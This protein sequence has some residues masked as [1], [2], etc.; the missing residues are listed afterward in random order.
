[1]CPLQ[2]LV[3]ARA[4]AVIGASAEYAVGAPEALASVWGSVDERERRGCA[5]RVRGA[6]GPSAFGRAWIVR[7]RPAPSANRQPRQLG[8]DH[9]GMVLL[10]PFGWHSVHGRQA[11]LAYPC[12]ECVLWFFAAF[13]ATSRRRPGQS[14]SRAGLSLSNRGKPLRRR[15][16]GCGE[17]PGRLERVRGI[18]PT[19]NTPRCTR[20]GS[21]LRHWRTSHPNMSMMSVDPPR[22]GDIA[23]G[24]LE[25]RLSQV[26]VAVEPQLY[27]LST[28][29]A[30]LDVECG[31]HHAVSCRG[32]SKL[33]AA[34]IPALART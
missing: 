28:R 27:D 34:P 30:R 17:R 25:I 20:D 24:P 8:I 3:E 9:G 18:V 12:V 2:A 22:I 7:A 11:L 16:R 26:Q 4:T 1:M 29:V 13:L 32:S 21:V 15:D 6:R 31:T 10:D 19:C 14:P 33:S 23:Q 5:G